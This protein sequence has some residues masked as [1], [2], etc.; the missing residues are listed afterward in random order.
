MKPAH[1]QIIEEITTTLSKEPDDP[2]YYSSRLTSIYTAIKLPAIPDK[3]Q[4]LVTKIKNNENITEEMLSRLTAEDINSIFL[5]EQILDYKIYT[6]LLCLAAMRGNI[7]NINLLLQKGASILIPAQRISDNPQD[8]SEK[9]TEYMSAAVLSLYNQKLDAAYHLITECNYPLHIQVT[10]QDWTPLNFAVYFYKLDK[11]QQLISRLQQHELR[12]EFPKLGAVPICIATAK[13]AIQLKKL[14]KL[15]WALKQEDYGFYI[16]AIPR[17]CH[18]NHLPSYTAITQEYTEATKLILQLQPAEIIYILKQIHGIFDAEDQSYITPQQAIPYKKSHRK[19]IKITSA[20]ETFTGLACEHLDISRLT[21]TALEVENTDFAQALI[22]RDV[23]NKLTPLHQK[24]IREALWLYNA[25]H[26]DNDTIIDLLIS[27]GVS[28]LQII[29]PIAGIKSMPLIAAIDAENFSFLTDDTST[30]YFATHPK[31]SLCLNETLF[32]Q[33]THKKDVPQVSPLTYAL[34]FK[35]DQAA[36]IL[37]D[38][39]CDLNNSITEL[40]NLHSKQTDI[41]NSTTTLKQAFIL[42]IKTKK[43]P[44]LI[45]CLSAEDMFD[46]FSPLA[47]SH[48][49]LIACQSLQKRDAKFDLEYE[50]KPLLYHAVSTKN[51]GIIKLFLSATNFV[52]FARTIHEINQEQQ[53]LLATLLTPKQQQAY[54]IE[55]IIRKDQTETFNALLDVVALQPT[56]FITA[57]QHN[58]SEMLSRLLTQDS[59]SGYAILNTA[60]E[61]NCPSSTTKPRRKRGK[62]KAQTK[63]QK[64]T[65]PLIE[66]LSSK[67]QP[68]IDTLPSPH[69]ASSKQ[70]LIIVIEHEKHYQ[71]P[72]LLAE[73]TKRNSVYFSDPDYRLITEQHGSCT[74]LQLATLCENIMAAKYFAKNSEYTYHIQTVCILAY[75]NKQNA[76]QWLKANIIDFENLFALSTS[77][78][79]AL[80]ADSTTLAKQIGF[81]RALI[82]AAEQKNLDLVHHLMKKQGDSLL[83]IALTAIFH[84][85][86]TLSPILTKLT[87][88]HIQELCQQTSTEKTPNWQ[89]FDWLVHKIKPDETILVAIFK[90]TLQQVKDCPNTTLFQ[91]I[92]FDL[93]TKPLEDLFDFVGKHHPHRVN[94]SKHI[95]EK[96]GYE[97]ADSDSD[98]P[99][100]SPL[101]TIYPQSQPESYM[102]A[103][104]TDQFRHALQFVTSL[105]SQGNHAYFC[106]NSARL[107]LYTTSDHPDIPSRTYIEIATNATPEI[108]AELVSATF[109]DQSLKIDRFQSVLFRIYKTSEQPGINIYSLP[110]LF[111]PAG[112]P[113][114]QPYMLNYDQFYINQNGEVVH[115][116]PETISYF[117]SKK[118]CTTYID[119]NK[120]ITTM[121][122]QALRIIYLFLEHSLSMP[123]D[124]KEVIRRNASLITDLPPI[125]KMKMIKQLFFSSNALIYVFNILKELHLLQ[126]LLPKLYNSEGNIR[127]YS[128]NWLHWR[129]S[130]MKYELSQNNKIKNSELDALIICLH[131]IDNKL[132]PDDNAEITTLI[133]FYC[134]EIIMND[135]SKLALLT[136]SVVSLLRD[137]ILYEKQCLS[138]PPQAPTRQAPTARLREIL[139][140]P[141]RSKSAPPETNRKSTADSCPPP[142]SPR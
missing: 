8:P 138:P 127:G 36:Q 119:L 51:Q 66:I 101:P 87:Q 134:D 70:S 88:C 106:G 6:T 120:A 1:E 74:A 105:C 108:V 95:A 140:I 3:L 103:L 104:Q 69:I 21:I 55:S 30:T 14:D 4:D 85:T 96:L 118:P 136:N 139:Y 122:T 73:L 126:P 65:T 12:I 47:V 32:T 117:R 99:L 63:S 29:E 2:D 109:P 71:Q 5:D 94:L 27:K 84:T 124:M 131:C 128:F 141:E 19:I 52:I 93:T 39:G 10:K 135:V 123:K 54:F 133:A 9:I 59:S 38:H 97:I 60:C 37:I 132:Y 15:E 77:D 62:R 41:D 33:T 107:L 137:Y 89:L 72:D 113:I 129:F 17:G 16:Q 68:L 112:L 20:H 50:G 45:G 130:I 25:I 79:P 42:A 18:F 81:D 46:E 58:R 57:V 53:R 13:T 92:A 7:H 86:K 31:I 102:T 11:F 75:N 76:L 67:K 98:I 111:D 142:P 110:K 24:N 44:A 80:E 48:E 125:H 90:N 26:L 61:I 64:T 56:A 23:R 82:V 49:S 114:M 116:I 35:K 78:K 100:S 91:L 43:E 121:P 22:E 83:Y 40:I 34:W 115:P 28:L